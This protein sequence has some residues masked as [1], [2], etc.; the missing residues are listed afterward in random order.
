LS[1]AA[2]SRPAVGNTP[3]PLL[4]ICAHPLGFVGFERARVGFLFSYADHRQGI[5]DLPALDFQLARQIVDSNF[6]HPPL[7]APPNIA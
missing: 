1:I 4:Q 7:Y 2:R 6:T 3:A 5:Q